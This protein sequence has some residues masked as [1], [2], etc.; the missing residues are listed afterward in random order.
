[1]QPDNRAL[2]SLSEREMTATRVRKIGFIF[3]AFHLNPI[4]EVAA[5]SNVQIT[6]RDGMIAT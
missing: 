4:L 1:M 5:M 2:H 6:L 3:Q